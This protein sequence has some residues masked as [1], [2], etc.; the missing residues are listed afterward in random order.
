MSYFEVS[1]S[2][3]N[4]QAK[5]E[6]TIEKSLPKGYASSDQNNQYVEV[7]RTAEEIFDQNVES[8]ARSIV[9]RDLRAFIEAKINICLIGAPGGLRTGL[10]NTIADD[11]GIMLVVIAGA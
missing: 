5:Q 9:H 6:T 11:L 4:R 2:F 7:C 1:P 8:D 10:I 3:M